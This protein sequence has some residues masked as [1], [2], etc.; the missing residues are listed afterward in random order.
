MSYEPRRHYQASLGLK[1]KSQAIPEAA[2]GPTQTLNY[3]SISGFHS[4]SPAHLGCLCIEF[5]IINNT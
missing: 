5:L 1:A 4:A 3:K 2:H